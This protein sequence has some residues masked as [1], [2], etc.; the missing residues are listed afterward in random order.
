MAELIIT[1]K[2]NAAQKVATALADN[3]PKKE[4][5]N[6]VPYYV[7]KHNGRD[8]IVACAVG[9]LYTVGETQKTPWSR[10]PVFDVAWV[11]TADVD[12]SADYSRKYL[13]TL[14]KLC[15]QADSY[16]VACDYDIEG[17]VIG[18]N[19][20]KECCKVKDAARM[21]F[22]TLTKQDLVKSYETK[23]PTLDWG[24]ANAGTTR[25]IL[26]FY[27]GINVTRALT[28]AINKAAGG[29]KV[30]STGRVQG[31]ALK[32]IVDREKEIKAFIP[33]PFWQIE[34]TGDI[35]G[36]EVKGLHKEDK[37]WEKEKADTV[38]QNVEGHKEGTISEVTK[39]QF[40]QNPPFPFD[41][42]SMQLEAYRCFKIRPKETLEIAQR[43]YTE[44][45]ISYPR[46]S[47]QKLPQ[48]LG[49]KNILTHLKRQEHYKALAE[50]ILQTKLVPNEGKKTDDAHPAIYPTGLAPDET[51]ERDYKIYDLIVK[52][53]M[54]VFAEPATRET[55]T[56]TVDVNKEEF[57]TKGTVTLEKGWHE[58]YAPYV[59][60]DET[61]LPVVQ[62]GDAVKVGDISCLAKE[63][64]PPNR[65]TQSSII[66][67]LEKKNLGT[68]ATRAQII[69]TLL[70]RGYVT[71]ESNLEA[72]ELGIKTV[73]TLEK[74]CSAILD[75]KLT[76]QFEDE[77]DLI[78]QNKHSPEQVL[79]KAQ[80]LITKI[81]EEFKNHESNLGGELS[82][83]NHEAVRQ[84]TTVGKC[85][86]CEE[87]ELVIR[88]G[89]FGRF[90]G[91]SNYPD[92]KT[93]YNLPNGGTVKPT[94][95]T[96]ESC[97]MPLVQMR[98]PRRGPQEIC[99][100]PHCPTKEEK[101]HYPEEGMQC[102]ACSEGKMILRNGFYGQF[103]GCD[104]YP[105]C[106]TM[107]K[108]VEGKVD[109]TPI[110][111]TNK[112]KKSKKKST[113][114]SSTKS[115]KKTKKSTTK[116]AAPKSATT[117]TT[118]K[119][120]KKSTAKSATTKAKKKSTKKAATKKTKKSTPKKT[121]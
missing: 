40:K 44:G 111:A 78:R 48:Q 7:L 27:Y 45:L 39:K 51:S 49:F 109:T 25:H 91:C 33:V 104:N 117:K 50:K 75:E 95:K 120:T 42:T 62:K 9:H 69:E 96:C 99:I 37:F 71:G 115:T 2:P 8:I 112:A 100:N 60:I 20:I 74:Y 102:P 10:Y 31:P 83:A 26:D 23:S 43:L 63:T 86:N 29:F 14:K 88:K 106:K 56:L 119:A 28:H 73:E 84:A 57:I 22:S 4:N 11:P 68:K 79:E 110:T 81:I 87:G 16:T 82:E 85:P 13:N 89:R 5:H 67:A 38:M 101:K 41:L 59:K 24:L 18:L 15:K 6:K 97:G 12:K 114:N 108:I 107:M 121:Q 94:D 105:K 65:Y 61:I 66:H 93:I 17:E 52:R 47:S 58:F 92:C 32:I 54:A 3:S 36:N 113:K 103:L 30:L 64:K 77:M 19:V 98:Q 46:T 35:K 34:L 53:F 21:K 80:K 90:I 72:T 118:K 1:E 116:K 55:N 70:Q 76:R